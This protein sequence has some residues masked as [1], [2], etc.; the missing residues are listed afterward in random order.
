MGGGGNRNAVSIFVFYPGTKLFS[1]RATPEV[2]SFFT[3]FTTKF[4]MG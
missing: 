1:Q 3:R 4:E 2:S